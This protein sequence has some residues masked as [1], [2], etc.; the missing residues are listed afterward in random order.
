MTS[1]AHTHAPSP[2]AADVAAG[3]DRRR[4]AHEPGFSMLRSSLASRLVI[5]AV[6]AAVLWSAVW[7]VLA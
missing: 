2:A 6:C 5:V 3:H 1:P 4:V 7:V